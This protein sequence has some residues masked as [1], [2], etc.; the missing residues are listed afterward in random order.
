MK[1]LFLGDVFGRSGRNALK[2]KLPSLKQELQA[3]VVIVNVD[4]VSNGRGVTQKHTKEILS[5]G[6]DCLTG[7]DHIWDQRDM[8]SG[9]ESIE[10]IIRPHN[11]AEGTLGSGIWSKEIDGQKITVFHLCGTVFMKPVFD[12]AF[13]CMDKFL[14]KHKVGKGHHIFIDFHAEATS[15]KMAM[16]HFLDGKVSAL[17]GSHTHVPTADTQVLPKGTAYQTDAGMCGDYNSVIGANPVGPIHNFLG[18]EPRM[19]IKPT[20]GESTI[21]GT[22]IETDDETGLANAIRPIRIGIYLDNTGL[23]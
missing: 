15:E 16:A 2:E 12:N 17:V 18:K 20:E 7:G 1:I 21:C 6:A 11:F 23:V 4:N 10:Q 5:Y 3:D 9:I 8:M 22:L 19:H 14:T 13:L